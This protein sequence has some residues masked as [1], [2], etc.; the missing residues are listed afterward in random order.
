MFDK[1]KKKENSNTFTSRLDMHRVHA[2]HLDAYQT[3]D[4]VKNVHDGV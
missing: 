3:K 2:T 4:S 1:E